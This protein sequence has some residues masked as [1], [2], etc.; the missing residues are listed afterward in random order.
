V[1]I[2]ENHIAMA[3]GISAAVGAAR[4]HA[5]DLPLEVEVR[6]GAEIDEALGAGA[7]HLLLDNMTVEELSAAVAR[8]GGRAELQASGGI[9][10]ETLRAVGSTGVDFISMGSLTHSA[11]A[12][13]LSLLV[14]LL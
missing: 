8:V 2:K 12:L 14:E 10:E 7:T 6:D 9:T 11:P 4:A 3:G 13:D 5:P 1:L